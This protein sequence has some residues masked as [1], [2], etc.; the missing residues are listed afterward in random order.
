MVTTMAIISLTLEPELQKRLEEAAELS[1]LTP[2]EMAAHAIEAFIDTKTARRKD[3]AKAL[4][5]ADRGDFISQEKMH[6]WMDS[7]DSEH[8][9]ASP[10][11][12][13]H[14]GVRRG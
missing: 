11:P 13:I 4:A 10:T 8:E 6:Q 3:L 12:D 2:S 7:W 1:S 9:L 5:D 14:A